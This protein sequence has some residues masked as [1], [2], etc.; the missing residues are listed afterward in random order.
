LV[1]LL[2]D[3]L[4]SE[5][6]KEEFTLHV[7]PLVEVFT[8]NALIISSS[9]SEGVIDPVAS[10]LRELPVAPFSTSNGVAPEPDH[11]C[12]AIE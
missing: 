12:T 9:S 7:L 11:A 4:W 1:P 8:P 3:P 10:E 2:F 6:V 5:I